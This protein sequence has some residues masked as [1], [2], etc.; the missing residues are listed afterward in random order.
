VG[1]PRLSTNDHL[2]SASTFHSLYAISS[3]VRRRAACAPGIARRCKVLCWWQL[4]PVVS[5]G[6]DTLETDT[7]TL[8]CLQTPTGA[9][10]AWRVASSAPP[11]SSKQLNSL[12]L[13]H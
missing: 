4:A 10:T 13:T 6:I 9:A 8:Q 2:R 5:S 7:F 1:L 12:S 3:Q 11:L